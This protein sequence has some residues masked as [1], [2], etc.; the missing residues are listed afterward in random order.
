MN[1]VY[2]EMSKLFS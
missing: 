1:P 2:A